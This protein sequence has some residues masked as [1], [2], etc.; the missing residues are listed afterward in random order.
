MEL[1]PEIIILPVR[2]FVGLEAPFIPSLSPR[3]NNLQVIPKLWTDFDHRF[4]EMKPLDPSWAYG[5]C[6]RPD[7]LA[8]TAADPDT[9]LYLAAVECS[10]DEV[11]PRGMVKWT[12]PEG[13]F[14]KFTHRG[15]IEKIGETMSVI[16]GKWLPAS[17]YQRAS[18]PDIEQMGPK[19][20]PQSDSS[21][22]EI[23]IP[24]RQ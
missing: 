23:L 5:L 12:S 24:V 19:F 16:Y 7:S 8:E 14:V 15:R 4:P 18:G 17:G 22:L 1:T 11:V 20:S 2:T 21:V 3:A 10:P 6:D 9:A 13:T